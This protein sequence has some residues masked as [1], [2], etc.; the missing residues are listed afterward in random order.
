M[1]Q[2]NIYIYIYIYP[3]S[4]RDVGGRE[5]G[6]GGR[7]GGRE[8]ICIHI[9]IYIHTRIVLVGQRLW[10]FQPAAAPAAIR[11]GW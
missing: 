4:W 9:Y 6:R 1:S 5:G 3:S 11:Q 10:P 7:E 8:S 2:T